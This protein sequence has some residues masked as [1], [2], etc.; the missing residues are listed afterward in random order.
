MKRILI[1]CF[2]IQ[3][4]IV[5]TAQKVTP[6]LIFELGKDEQ[7]YRDLCEAYPETLLTWKKDN[8]IQSALLWFDFLK[9]METYADAIQFNLYG[10]KLWLHI[11]WNE[12]GGIDHIG[13]YIHP[14]SR[15]IQ[16]AELNAF[17]SAFSRLAKKPD[18]NSGLKISH[19][20]SASFP[21]FALKR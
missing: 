14:E 10:L 2:I 3:I 11:F 13:Y 12:Q 6:Q 15:Q 18:V 4:P 17:L 1:L 19:Y 20:T 16:Q 21:T 8:Y 5:H 9:S 7:H